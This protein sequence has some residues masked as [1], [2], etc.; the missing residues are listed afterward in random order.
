M[1]ARPS[2]PQPALGPDRYVVLGNPVEHSRS[3]WIHTRFAELTGEP[4]AYGKQLVALDGFASALAALRQQGVKGC[5]VTVPFKFEAFAA[6]TRH[7]QR[8][9][10]AGACNTL[11]FQGDEV[12]GDNTD[13]VG[14]VRDI[15][16]N[17]GVPLCGARV[18]LLGA[19]G[20]AAGVLGP[21]LD[22]RPRELVV[23]NRT[24]AKAQ[25]LVASHA[26]H[27]K[28]QKCELSAQHSQAIEGVFD[29]ILNATASS[30][31]GGDVPAP[32]SVLRPGALAVDLMYGPAAQP[33]LAWAARHGATGRDG[34]GMLVEQAAA[35]FELWRGVRPPGAQV[36]AELATRLSQART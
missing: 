2:P 23:C 8:A 1:N 12:L 21:L 11:A 19:G 22:E 30:L 18:L 9:E 25:A 10:L 28:N 32:D 3:P 33:F 13:G 20:A 17:A 26:A 5:N 36:L 15:T 7:T 35:A 34:L 6:A 4:M 14:L 31:G 24:A 29:V 16:V 27:A